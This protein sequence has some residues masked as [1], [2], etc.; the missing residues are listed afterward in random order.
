MGGKMYNIEFLLSFANCFIWIDSYKIE[1]S[2]LGALELE[3]W[4][5]EFC[6]FLIKII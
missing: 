5:S 2:I 6:S 4:E 3:K 1:K